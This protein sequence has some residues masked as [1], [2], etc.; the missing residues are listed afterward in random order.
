MTPVAVLLTSTGQVHTFGNIYAN[1]RI[2]YLPTNLSQNNCSR[3]NY[4]ILLVNL[5]TRPLTQPKISTSYIR[6]SS[7]T[8]S[9]RFEFPGE[10]ISEFSATVQINPALAQTYFQGVDVSQVITININP[11][12][13]ALQDTAG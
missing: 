9:V 10:P 3:C 4:N 13:M 5:T 11:A 7:Y 1:V 2:N 8:F 12:V 6:G